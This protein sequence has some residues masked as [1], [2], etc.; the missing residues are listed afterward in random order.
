M[1]AE[2]DVSASFLAMS[3]ALA[4]GATLAHNYWRYQ[5]SL[6]AV[7]YTPGTKS[8]ISPTR[9]IMA[10]IPGWKVPFTDWFISIGLNYWADK[11]YSSKSQS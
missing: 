8:L 4:I 1:F 3:G 7:G 6:Q 11:R 9:A 5:Q 2:L 10:V